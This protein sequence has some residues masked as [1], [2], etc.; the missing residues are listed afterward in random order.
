MR[1]VYF[2]LRGGKATFPCM[3]CHSLYG[4][5]PDEH[6]PKPPGRLTTVRSEPKLEG[7]D[8]VRKE[9]EYP[10]PSVRDRRE[11]EWTLPAPCFT[12]QSSDRNPSL[13]SP[14]HFEMP[15]HTHRSGM[16]VN[17]AATE[18][19]HILPHTQTETHSTHQLKHT[20]IKLPGHQTNTHINCM[21][22]TTTVNTRAIQPIYFERK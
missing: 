15:T 11:G 14:G 10:L 21:H 2:D 3:H 17:E 22:P 12:L 13:H 18:K 1:C 19:F 6:F 16:G 4:P 5:G 7:L 8:G 9:D 20:L